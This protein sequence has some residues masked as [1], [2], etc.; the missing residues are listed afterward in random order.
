M[1]AV[2]TTPKG[3]R[4]REHILAAARRVFAR[5]GFVGATMSNIADEAG[6]SLGGLY[7]YFTNK[8]D[9]FESLIS[10]IHEELFQASGATGQDFRSRPFEALLS[11][12][13]GYLG[14]YHAN[15]D[16]M[17]TLVE[18]ANVDARFRDFWWKMRDR[19]IDRFV[20]ALSKQHGIDQIDGRPA[21]LAA[22]A[23]ACMVEQSAYL[24]F[25]HESL[26]GE[27]VTV[28]DAAAIVTRA[29]YSLFFSQDSPAAPLSAPA[30][31][32]RQTTGNGT[33]DR[34]PD[35]D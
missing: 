16:V 19:H 24:W 18:A 10:G 8:E 22:E 21:R 34:A 25:A 30:D 27:P 2:P 1:P 14:C 23:A 28:D 20:A 17:R 35:R 4:T 7:R 31:A 11:A 9:V 29:W 6:I 33:E 3:K 15:R 13:R 12:N 5:D 32:T 26:H